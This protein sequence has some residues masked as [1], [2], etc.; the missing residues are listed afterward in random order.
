M[1]PYVDPSKEPNK[2][3]S[4]VLLDFLEQDTEPSKEALKVGIKVMADYLEPGLIDQIFGT[5]IEQYKERL[6]DVKVLATPES[7]RS[8]DS[9]QYCQEDLQ[10]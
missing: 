7:S 2:W 1:M 3:L 5:W 4:A 10:E 6:A 8:N 9:Q